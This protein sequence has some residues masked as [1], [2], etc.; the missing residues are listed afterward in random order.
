MKVRRLR[1]KHKVFADLAMYRLC[2]SIQLA[3]KLLD[4]NPLN[5][6]AN[7][8]YKYNRKRLVNIR[9]RCS[10]SAQRFANAF[11]RLYG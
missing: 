3:N 10:K 2:Q 1:K 6:R 7:A 5:A 9:K 11:L 4:S 8:S